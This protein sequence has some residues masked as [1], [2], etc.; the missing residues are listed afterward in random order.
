MEVTTLQTLL[1]K[2]KG[3]WMCHV[4]PRQAHAAIESADALLVVFK[5]FCLFMSALQ[6]LGRTTLDFGGS[7]L[8]RS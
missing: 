6:S 3:E 4:V 5:P 1:Q 7:V 2:H 8:D